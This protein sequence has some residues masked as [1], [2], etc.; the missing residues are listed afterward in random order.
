MKG[1]IFVP[2]VLVYFDNTSE[3]HKVS[4]PNASRVYNSV[5]IA[6]WQHGE[7]LLPSLVSSVVSS[8]KKSI[9]S[10]ERRASLI[11]RMKASLVR[12]DY[13]QIAND[14]EDWARS[15]IDENAMGWNEIRCNRVVRRKFNP[16]GETSCYIKVSEY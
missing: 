4:R 6:S 3:Q 1:L 16:T 7:S 11:A 9:M 12:P 15:L 10:P 2:S 5:Q 8:M 14:V 13:E